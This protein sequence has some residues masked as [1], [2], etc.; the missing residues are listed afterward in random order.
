[1]RDLGDCGQRKL[2]QR[3]GRYR[4]Q[5]SDLEAIN[6]GLSESLLFVLV[7]FSLLVA[8]L[9]NPSPGEIFAVLSYV[10]EFAEGIYALPILFQQMIRVKEISR[11]LSGLPQQLA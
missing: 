9:R 7:M 8:A 5:L 6:F 2:G 10:I 4:I 1:L 3:A 11:R